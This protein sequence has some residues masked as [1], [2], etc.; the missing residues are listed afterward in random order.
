MPGDAA[1]RRIICGVRFPSH[2]SAADS[3]LLEMPDQPSGN[4]AE[5]GLARQRALPGYGD[6]PRRFA[7]LLQ[8]R[9]SAGDWASAGGEATDFGPVGW[10]LGTLAGLIGWTAFRRRRGKAK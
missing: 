8:R 7:G 1:S 9:E 5:D 2:R 4:A 3:T 6:K 10:L